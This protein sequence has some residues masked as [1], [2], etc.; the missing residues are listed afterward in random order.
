MNATKKHCQPVKQGT[1]SEGRIHIPERKDIVTQVNTWYQMKGRLGEARKW[2]AEKAE[3]V[4]M[5]GEG[6]YI[7]Q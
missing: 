3:A 4:E 2:K 6:N 1:M 5:E 7:F